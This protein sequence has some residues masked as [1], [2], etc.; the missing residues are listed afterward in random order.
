MTPR[1][2]QVSAVAA[3]GHLVDLACPYVHRL[4]DLRDLCRGEAFRFRHS[5]DF[6]AVRASELGTGDP[7]F[8]TPTRPWI[9]ENPGPKIPAR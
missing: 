1:Q 9:S 2:V 3:D 7:I 6:V 8:S 5:A 4:A